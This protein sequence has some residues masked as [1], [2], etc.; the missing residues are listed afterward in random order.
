[1]VLTARRW[2]GLVN[3][4]MTFGLKIATIITILVVTSWSFRM[5]CFVLG[6]GPLSF[7]RRHAES[8]L[9]EDMRRFKFRRLRW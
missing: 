2:Q 6:K 5:L 3:E 9:S 1:M 8:E 4:S 7:E